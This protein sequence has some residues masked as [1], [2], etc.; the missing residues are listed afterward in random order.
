MI[1]GEFVII[2]TN[3]ETKLRKV[4]TDPLTRGQAMSWKAEK[5]IKHFW[6]DFRVAQKEGPTAKACSKN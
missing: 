1:M 2:A 5:R 4:I 3:R 6:K